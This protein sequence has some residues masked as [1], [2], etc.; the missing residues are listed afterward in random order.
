MARVN[1]DDSFFYDPRF[2]YLG[3]LLGVDQFSVEARVIRVWKFCTEQTRER[4]TAEEINVHAHWFNQDEKCFA[5]AM[6]QARLAEL[7]PSEPGPADTCYRIKGAKERFAWLEERRRAA[8]KGGDATKDTFDH[9]RKKAKR[10]PKPSQDTA[11]ESQTRPSE[12]PLDIVPSLDL[13]LVTDRGEEK[14]PPAALHPLAEIWNSVIA[15][16]APNAEV[17][18]MGTRKKAA[19]ARWREKPDPKYWET[20]IARAVLASHFCRGINDRGW[21]ADFEWMVRPDTHLKIMEGKYDNR[22][23]AGPPRRM[24]TAELNSQANKELFEKVSRGEA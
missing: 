9:L 13:D 2:P 16:G 1:I 12:G 18:E 15:I 17:R 23:R 7:V 11:K 5:N 14:S 8:K 19:E 21:L 24:T 10:R 3:R 20:V 4:L 6:V 22:E